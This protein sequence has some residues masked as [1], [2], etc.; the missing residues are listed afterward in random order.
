MFT[1][2]LKMTEI[3]TAVIKSLKI[4]TNLSEE[5]IAFTGSLWINGKKAADLK[6]DG[7]G[8]AN[9]AWFNDRELEKAFDAYCESLPPEPQTDEWAIERGLDAMSM[10]SDLWISLEVGKIDEARYW[11]RKCAKTMCIILKSHKEGQFIQYKAWPYTTDAAKEVREKY[12][13]D[14]LEIVNERFL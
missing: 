12:G 11:K 2:R 1:G 14:L 13:D 4:A 3:K 8:G 7:Q 9:F 6:N 5:T 10:D